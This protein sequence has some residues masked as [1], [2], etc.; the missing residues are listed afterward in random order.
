MSLLAI[1]SHYFYSWK[2]S[3]VKFYILSHQLTVISLRN[4]WMSF[5]C[6]TFEG[7]EDARTVYP[8][9][10][11]VAWMGSA[12][13]TLEFWVVPSFSDIVSLTSGGYPILLCRSLAACAVLCL[14]ALWIW[15]RCRWQT[16]LTAEVF[17][18]RNHI[19]AAY[20]HTNAVANVLF[21]HTTPIIPWMREVSAPLA[22][23]RHLMVRVYASSTTS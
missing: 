17:K 18:S 4:Y 12:G 16:V 3:W 10:V 7:W 15:L 13:R 20:Y 21:P 8:G 2:S 6:A 14:S 5:A 19:F 22:L 23:L 1:H 9:H 11:I